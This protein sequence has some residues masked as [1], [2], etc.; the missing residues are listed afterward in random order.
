YAAFEQQVAGARARAEERHRRWANE[1]ERFS[2]L[3]RDRRDE[4]RAGGSQA[5]RRATRAAASKVRAA[6]RALRN[7]ERD[8]AEKPWRAWELKLTLTLD[9]RPGDTLV[10]LERAVGERGRFRLG[11]LELTIGWRE[12][13][14]LT[15]PNGT[16]KSTLLRMV[17]G[18]LPLAEG[19]RWVGPR[20]TI[21]SLDQSRSLFASERPL[22]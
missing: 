22:V 3:K 11:P 1:H 9:E 18:E 5:N 8:K 12:R 15:G 20:V 13:I 6:D 2:A 14:L 19:T 10:R 21:A 16:G 7:L 4:A 17:L